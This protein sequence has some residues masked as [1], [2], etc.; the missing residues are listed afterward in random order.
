MVYLKKSQKSSIYNIELSSV[1]IPYFYM[2]NLLFIFFGATTVV[3][4][5]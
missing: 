5:S 3:P 1:L 2:F 4:F